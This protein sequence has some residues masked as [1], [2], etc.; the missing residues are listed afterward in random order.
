MSEQIPSQTPAGWYPDPSMPSTQRYWDG[1]QWTENLAP[2]GAAYG[3]TQTSTY[4]I[5]AIVMAFV[6]FPLAIVFG[7]MGRNE[8]DA[9]NGTKTGRGLATAGMWI[10]IGYAI[11]I[12]A[13]FVLFFVAAAIGAS[14]SN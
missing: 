3:Q 12:V 11:F 6:F 2:M 13:F 1:Q 14:L 4:A 5:L 7:I 8:I 9:S 10:G